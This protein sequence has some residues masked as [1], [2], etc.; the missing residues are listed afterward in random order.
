MVAARGNGSERAALLSREALATARE[1][2]MQGV[3]ARAAALQERLG[4]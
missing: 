1:L 4:A 3:A 2:G